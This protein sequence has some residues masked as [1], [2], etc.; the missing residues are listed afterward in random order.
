MT[1]LNLTTNSVNWIHYT[2]TAK[3][4]GI[5]TFEWSYSKDRRDCGGEDCVKIDNVVLTHAEVDTTTP[6]PT[7]KPTDTP[8]PTE[9][10]TAPPFPT[11]DADGGG[12][13][14]ISDALTILRMAM[15]I[16]N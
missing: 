4:A 6:A 3:T 12:N 10:P 15:G 16:Q 1:R 14:T 5:Y 9:S 11:G 2:Y 8:T 13:I 7:I